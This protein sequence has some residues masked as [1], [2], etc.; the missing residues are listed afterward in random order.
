VN[1]SVSVNLV[2]ASGSASD[3]NLIVKAKTLFPGETYLCP[4]LVGQVMEPGGFISTLASAATSL[5]FRVSGR[6]IA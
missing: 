2:A 4:E 5:T 1:A 3:G 6:E